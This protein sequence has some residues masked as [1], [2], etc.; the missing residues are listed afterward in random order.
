MQTYTH[1]QLHMTRGHARTSQR[2]AHI[3]VRTVPATLRTT[4]EQH[5]HRIRAIDDAHN[6][7]RVTARRVVRA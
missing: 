6:S 4:G 1:S 3:R 7:H 2:T 5:G